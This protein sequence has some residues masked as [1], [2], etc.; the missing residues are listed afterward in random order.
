MVGEC[1]AAHHALTVSAALQILNG[2]AHFKSIHAKVCAV[3][4]V[5]NH[6]EAQPSNL[7]SLL[8]CLTA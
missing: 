3:L 4:T 6:A 5:P 8:F 1:L 7:S 2:K